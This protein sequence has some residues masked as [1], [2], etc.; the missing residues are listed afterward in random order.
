MASDNSTENEGSLVT[1]LA[2]YNLLTSAGLSDC[3]PPITKVQDPPDYGRMKP[4]P[5]VSPYIIQDKKLVCEKLSASRQDFTNALIM[6]EFVQ[7]LVP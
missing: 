7:R 5:L 6:H 2:V 3:N 1:R 4:F